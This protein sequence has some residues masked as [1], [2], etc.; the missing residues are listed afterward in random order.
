ML[1]VLLISFCA[2]KFISSYTQVKYGK[3]SKDWFDLAI[4]SSITSLMAMAFFY[5]TSGFS[6]KINASTVWCALFYALGVLSIHYFGLMI[7]KH[8][9]IL[10]SGFIKSGLGLIATLCVCAVVFKEEITFVSIIRMIL[11]MAAVTTL[12]LVKNKDDRSNSKNTLRGYVLCGALVI[13]DIVITLINKKMAISTELIDENSCFFIVNVF[14]FVFSIA[15]AFV[16]KKGRIKEFAVELKT[17]PLKKYGYILASTLS[18][19]LGSLLNV[20]ILANGMPVI[21]FTPL[22]T[23][24]GVVVT[25]V[26]ARIIAKEKIPPIPVILSLASALL[27]VVK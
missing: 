6:I 7:Y 13:S 10:D 12:S 20:W 16:L 8:M 5:F 14:T 24:I 17:F 4:Y 21:L 3:K 19:N 9:R 22:N 27:S 2:S 23:A 11:S 25:V 26:I 1:Y 18:S 15:L